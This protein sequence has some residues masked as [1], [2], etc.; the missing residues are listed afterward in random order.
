MKNCPSTSEIINTQTK[1]YTQPINNTN[2]LNDNISN[3]S[4][5][6]E[7]LT[8]NYSHSQETNPPTLFENSN[9]T[10]NTQLP[11]ITGNKRGHSQCTSPA[12]DEITQN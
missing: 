11:L 1:P 12:S 10:I 8:L 3:D 7:D 6:I 9:V 4:S 2:N 5:N